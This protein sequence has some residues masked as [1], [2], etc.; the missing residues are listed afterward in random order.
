M[1]L[2]RFWAFLFLV[3]SSLTEASLVDEIIKAIEDA[4]DCTTCHALLIPLQVLAHLG[5]TAFVDT[6]T[7]ICQTL[8]VCSLL[9]QPWGTKANGGLHR[10][11]TTMFAQGSSA[12][13]AP[14][15]PK[16]F[17][18]S[19]QRVRPVPDSAAHLLA[20]ASLLPSTPI[21]CPFPKLH[22]LHP[23]SGSR[24]DSLLSKCSTFRMSISTDSIRSVYH[25]NSPTRVLM[26][27]VPRAARVGGKLHEADML[28]ELRRQHRHSHGTCRSLWQ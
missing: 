11:R 23:R 25:S 15:S 17:A 28:Q 8:K 6:V 13:K 10:P 26:L 5:D 22:P 19:R 18:R 21:T 20:F 1:L 2:L 27:V 24:P 4:V 14:S 3:L 9:A 12:S 7:T 16:T